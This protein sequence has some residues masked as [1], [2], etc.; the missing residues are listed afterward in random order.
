MRSVELA[1]PGQDEWL[2]PA[3]A[4]VDPW[5]EADTRDLVARVRAGDQAAWTALTRRFS[6]LLWSVARGMNM[7]TEDAA[8]AVQT[9]WLRLVERLD[10]IREPERV[11]GWLATSVRRE[12]LGILRRHRDVAMPDALEM[13]SADDPPDTGLLRDERDAQLWRAMRRLPPRCASLL[14]MLIADP[15]PSYQDVAATLQLPMGSIG[16]TRQRC[17]ALLRKMLGR[18]AAAGGA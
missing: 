17:L 8:D 7:T 11:G 10:D 12:C 4:A 3:G 14:R 13:P 6:G 16:P 18:T 9:T 15:P 1:A 2:G 5:R